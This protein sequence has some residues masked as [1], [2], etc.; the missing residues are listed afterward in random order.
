MR[1]DLLAAAVFIS[2]A[3]F[4][5]GLGIE[6][7][8]APTP[9]VAQDARYADIHQLSEDIAKIRGITVMV[10]GIDT[11]A[12]LK[13]LADAIMDLDRRLSEVERKAK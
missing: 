1:N 2:M 6:R 9:V 3:I 11:N 4:S 5:F 10:G 7:V 13:S 8:L 12:A